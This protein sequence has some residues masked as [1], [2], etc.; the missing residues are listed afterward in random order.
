M[1]LWCQVLDVEESDID[2]NPHFFDLGGDC[3]AA[4]R[5]VRAASDHG[6]VLD[7]ITVFEH[8]ELEVMASLCRETELK[9]TRVKVPLVWMKSSFVPAKMRVVLIVIRSRIFTPAL[10]SKISS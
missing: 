8:P 9:T 10:C 1:N 7:N 6:L 5:L 4:I 2:N 3:V